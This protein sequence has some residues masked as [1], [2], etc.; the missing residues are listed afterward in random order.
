M[1]IRKTIEEVREDIFRVSNGET[2]LISDTYINNKTPLLLQCSCGD[3]FERCLDRIVNRN[4]YKCI[5]CSRNHQSEIN[6]KKMDEV[7]SIIESKGCKYISG[8][9]INYSSL[10]TIQCVC[11]ELFTR[12]LS[13]FIRGQDRCEKCWH[14]QIIEKKTKYTSNDAKRIFA[15]RKYVMVGEYVNAYTPVSCVCKNG[16]SCNLVLSQFLN[17]RSG[18]VKCMRD[19]QKGKMSH[20]YKDG[21]ATMQ[22]SIR[23]N[24]DEWKFNVAEYYNWTCP[25]T[26]VRFESCDVHHIKSLKSIYNE[27]ASSY[28]IDLPLKSKMK[29]Y[30]SYEVF[31]KIRNEVVKAHTVDMGIYISSGVHRSFHKLYSQHN[32]TP[33]QFEDFLKTMYGTC[34]QE[35]QSINSSF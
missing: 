15:S 7:I 32:A 8:D 19:N 35:I 9:Y 30:P 11:N 34:L 20:F 22:D 24:L 1:P 33:E 4:S 12:D 27:V 5:K 23:A 3:L 25:L 26:G 6:R 21:N 2:K 16:H 17:N 31:D 10:L 14:K 29:D 28:G 18:C 13:H